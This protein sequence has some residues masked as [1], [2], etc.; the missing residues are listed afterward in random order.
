M[1]PTKILNQISYKSP[2]W[3]ETVCLIY[4]LQALQYVFKTLWPSDTIWRHRS[5][6]T[7]AQ[8]MASSKRPSHYLNQCWLMIKS[9]VAITWEQYPP[10]DK[11]LQDCIFKITA[12]SPRVQWLTIYL[13]WHGVVCYVIALAAPGLSGMIIFW[14]FLWFRSWC[15]QRCNVQCIGVFNLDFYVFL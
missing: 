10:H 9:F 2:K 7:L 12:A 8:V 15:G 1:K 6:S 11:N 5:G 14:V 3:I 4:T 13:S